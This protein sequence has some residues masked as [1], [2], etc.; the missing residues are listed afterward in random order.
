MTRT[1]S[2]TR[3][4]AL[5]SAET[6]RRAATLPRHP[7]EEGGVLANV[8]GRSDADPIEGIWYEGARRM[9]VIPGEGKG[10]YLAVVTRSDT[11][12]LPVGAVVAR[13]AKTAP[14]SLP[15]RTA[16]QLAG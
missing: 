12:T 2:S 1:S 11:A 6:I 15:G 8:A 14:E 7:V 4:L 5:D 9:A 10:K 13:I 16:R 3:V